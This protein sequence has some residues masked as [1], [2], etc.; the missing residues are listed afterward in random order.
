MYWTDLPNFS[1]KLMEIV[2]SKP[3][4]IDKINNIKITIESEEERIIF[5]FDLV[6]C[7]P[8]N[9]PQKWVNRKFNRS[10]IRL[11]CIKVFDFDIS[12]N[13]IESSKPVAINFDL[14]EGNNRLKIM[15]DTF[16]IEISCDFI[17]IEEFSVYYQE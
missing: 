13:F 10:Q 9:P 12:S 17:G 11:S 2:F 16:Q 5:H 14:T 1:Q 4:K 3:P 8:D 6:D 7:L 15:D